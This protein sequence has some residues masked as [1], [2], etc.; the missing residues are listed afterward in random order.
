ML[1][2]GVGPIS[3][4]LN[5]NTGISATSHLRIRRRPATPAFFGS[6]KFPFPEFAITSPLTSYRL[7]VLVS[8][9]GMV[10][11]RQQKRLAASVAGV[12]KRKSE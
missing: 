10:N 9:H 2:Q 3:V 1:D 5:W 11:L 4:E 7:I 6:A 12:G 8:Q